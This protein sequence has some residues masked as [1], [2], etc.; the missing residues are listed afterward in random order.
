[1][2]LLATCFHANFLIGLFFEPED[3]DMFLRNISLISANY[4]AVSQKIIIFITT[5]MRTYNPKCLIIFL[6][7]SI[8]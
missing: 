3:E 8:K 1:M 7:A 6:W 2:A 5:A 4:M